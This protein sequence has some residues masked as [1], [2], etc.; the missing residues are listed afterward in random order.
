MTIINT[1]ENNV[2]RYIYIYTIKQAETTIYMQF[3]CQSSH[4]FYCWSI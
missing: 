3:I 4:S 1:V 2:H